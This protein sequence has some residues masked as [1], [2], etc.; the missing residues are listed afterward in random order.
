MGTKELRH[1]WLAASR[2]ANGLRASVTETPV[3]RREALKRLSNWNKL[4]VVVGVVVAISFT[5]NKTFGLAVRVSYT[6]GFVT[7]PAFA[8]TR[9]K[10][11]NL[12]LCLRANRASSPNNPLP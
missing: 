10:R 4:G 8:D 6:L 12:V 11:S 9:R 3:F 2:P 1:G 7:P 5:V